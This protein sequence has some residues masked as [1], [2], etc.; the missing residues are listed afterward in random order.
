[1]SKNSADEKVDEKRCCAL[2]EIC[3]YVRNLDG[4]YGTLLANFACH[5]YGNRI[6][7]TELMREISSLRV[8]LKCEENK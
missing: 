7:A 1:M 2:K 8:M 5:D 3:K 4:I 6:I